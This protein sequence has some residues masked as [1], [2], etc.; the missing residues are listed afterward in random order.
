MK[1]TLATLITI[2]ALGLSISSAPSSA[3]AADSIRFATEA[4]YPPFEFIGDNNELQGFDIDLAN[5]I[6]EQLKAECSFSNQPFDSLIPSLKFRRFDAIISGMDITPARLKQ[7][8]FSQPYYEN[9]ATFVAAT[10]QG[11]SSV[12][13]L[14]GKTVGVQNGSTHQTYIID[15]LESQ[16]VK[17]RPYDS[18]QNA[19]LDMTNGRIDSV[20][21]D[22]AV[23]NE[24]LSQR[25]NDKYAAVGEAV[26]DADYFG[27]GYGIAIRQ[28][29]PLKSQLDTAL[30]TLKT[31]G[32]YQTIYDKYFTKPAQQ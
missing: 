3:Q 25:G 19:F 4:T 1:K 20:F 23:A 15:K 30:N 31:N 26:R 7:V 13:S 12:D 18:F 10:S 2:G 24:W 17:V 27:V 14:K 22:T 29:D 16:G 21:S 8:D 32:T 9:S 5:A 28:D 11:L 6:C